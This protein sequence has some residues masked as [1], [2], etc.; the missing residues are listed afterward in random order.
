MFMSES[1][2]TQKRHCLPNTALQAPHEQEPLQHVVTR[3]AN[4]DAPYLEQECEDRTFSVVGCICASVCGAAP[5]TNG[6][7]MHVVFI[8]SYQGLTS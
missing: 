1:N 5:A 2:F 7:G 8:V 3:I 4:G 6:Q